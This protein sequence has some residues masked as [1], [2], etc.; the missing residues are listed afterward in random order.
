MPLEY[1]KSYRFTEISAGKYRHTDASGG[2]QFN[3]L[4]LMLEGTALIDDGKREV[5]LKAGDVFFIPLGCR[6]H[7][8]WYGDDTVA[9]TSLAFTELPELDAGRYVLQKLRVDGT[10]KRRIAELGRAGTVSCQSVGE[11][12]RLLG[13]LIPEMERCEMTREQIIIDAASRYMESEPR[14]S[15]RDTARHCGISESGLYAAFRE[16]GTTPALTKQELMIERALSLITTTDLNA[17]E[18]AERVG[19]NSTAYFLRVLKKLTGKTTRE[20][21]QGMEI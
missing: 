15:V 14:A 4:A 6:Y 10:Q 18:I 11:L 16:V 12:Y 5:A 9:W 8:Y 21:R 19:F 20:L 1:R 17:D 3:Y 13:E 7:S 2:S